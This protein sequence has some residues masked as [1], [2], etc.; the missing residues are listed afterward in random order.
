MAPPA[1]V[2]AEN[3]GIGQTNWLADTKR[4]FCREQQDRAALLVKLSVSV[5]AGKAQF[6]LP[7]QVLLKVQA[8]ISAL[9]ILTFVR[10]IILEAGNRLFGSD[11]PRSSF[12][13][14]LYE[15]AKLT[16]TTVLKSRPAW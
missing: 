3:R 6:L 7:V 12:K 4:G 15:H 8:D 2:D 16:I 11:F 9:A 5:F 13:E 10:L 1:N 14:I